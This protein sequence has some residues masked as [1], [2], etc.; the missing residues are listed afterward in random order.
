M[1]NNRP[2]SAVFSQKGEISNIVN[3]TPNLLIRG[4]STYCLADNFR[5]QRHARPADKLN[6]INKVYR[7]RQ[8]LLRLFW[9]QFSSSYVRML[10]FT[11]R[12][13][14][15]FT[16]DIPEGTFV[17]LREENLKKNET[18][19]LVPALV[20]EVYRREDGLIN[21]LKVR[22]EG[23]KDEI[24]RHIRDF[25]LME[26]DYLKITQ[27]L[28]RCLI[29]DLS[30][31]AKV[32]KLEAELPLD[33]NTR[34]LIEGSGLH[35]DAEDKGNAAETKAEETAPDSDHD[36]SSANNGIQTRARTHGLRKRSNKN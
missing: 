1:L 26:N 12:W 33:H 24:L 30:E 3:I 10:K 11:K 4:Q 36:N 9:Q 28:H 20:T 14:Q 32:D 34:Q 17:L 6:D 35:E 27:P 19:R 21:Q 13:H 16:Q 29:H 22:A 5:F 31:A 23:Y 8:H 15:S 25:A 7:D 18:G 2:L